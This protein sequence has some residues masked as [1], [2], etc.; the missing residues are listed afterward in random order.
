[1]TKETKRRIAGLVAILMITGGISYEEKVK[2]KELKII[3]SLKEVTSVFE[4]DTKL[5]EAVEENI[6]AYKKMPITEAADYLDESI[7]I[8]KM[9]NTYDFSEVNNLD[10][11]TDEEYLLAKNLTK[12]DIVLITS[13]LE[14]KEDSDS[15]EYEEARI[16]SIKMLAHAKETRKNWIKKHGKKAVIDT[17]D[18]VVK[19]SIA[20]DLNI[21]V[22]KI[23]QIKMPSVKKVTDMKFYVTYDDNKYYVGNSSDIFS[24]LYYRY[25]IESTSDFGEQEYDVYKE[26]INSAK[27]VIMTGVDT[28]NHKFSNERTIKEAKRVLKRSKSI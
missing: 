25:Q 6:A 11:L 20:E 21:P 17:I 15:L 27:I 16:K 26:G 9:L 7:D 28:K 23:N 3:E 13:V 8:V 18:W 4:S 5:D 1:M 14:A 12:E 19:S 22:E 10:K 2:N 24:A